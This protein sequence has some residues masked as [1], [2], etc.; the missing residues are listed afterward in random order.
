MNMEFAEILSTLDPRLPCGED[1][2]YDADFLRLQQ[3]AAERSE[4]QFGTTIIPA[5]PPDWLEVEKQALALLERTRDIRVIAHLTRAWT[6]TRG[7]PGYADGLT[8]CA[9]A[10]ERYWEA[11]HPR[12]DSVGEN[13]PLPRVNAL[14]SLGDVHGCARSARSASLIEGVHGNLSL[15]EAESVLD[16]S[17]A[18]SDAYPGGR[19]RL[20][21]HLRQAHLA[22]DAK[23]AALTAAARA[24]RYI[25]EL[26]AEKLGSEW[27]PDYN[28]I[29][30]S[31]DIVAQDLQ[32]DLQDMAAAASEHR[33]AAGDHAPQAA[34]NAHASGARPGAPA[35]PL[36]WQDAQIQS[37]AEAA[38]ML[39]KVC[40]YFEVHEPGHPAPYLIRRAQQLIP[41]S[42]HDIIRNLAPQGLEQFEAWLPR[43]AEG[44]PAP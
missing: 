4:Q 7:L 34:G 10:L 33:D 25:Q 11:V 1:L 15:R 37:R 19:A 43:D 9:D 3:S 26:V 21:E 31:L 2:E 20:V 30:R 14:A 28:V 27:M 44:R 17:R 13:D 24:L 35:A 36:R 5:Q 16:G 6:E 38:A 39:T 8:L 32:Q 18:L 22:G 29:L 12:L 23:L 40:A 41:L 42:F